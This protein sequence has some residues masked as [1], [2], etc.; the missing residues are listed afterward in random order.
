MEDAGSEDNTGREGFSY[1]WKAFVLAL[2]MAC[3]LILAGVILVVYASADP[4]KDFAPQRGLDGHVQ[5]RT[6]QYIPP[7]ISNSPVPIIAVPSVPSMPCK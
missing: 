3:A 4:Y 6:D 1:F 7:V 5:F 2:C